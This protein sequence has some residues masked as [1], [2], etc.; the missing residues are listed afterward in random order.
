MSSDGPV[1]LEANAGWDTGTIQRPHDRPLGRT[2]FAA[3]VAARLAKRDDE[4]DL[5]HRR[6]GWKVGQTTAPR[7]PACGAR[8][9]G[10]DG[11]GRW[12]DGAVALGHQHLRDT[13]ESAGERPGPP[14]QR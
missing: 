3:L 8:S 2:R 1:L 6:D 9:Y 12:I 5:R 11:N 4:R 14:L 7:T 10:P 13:P